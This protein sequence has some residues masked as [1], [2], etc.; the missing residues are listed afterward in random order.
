MSVSPY[1]AEELFGWI[2]ASKPDF[3]LL[4]V[5]TE[6]DYKRFKV[7][8]PKPFEM[9]NVPYIEFSD[10]EEEQSV[11][12]V[13]AGRPIRIVC[14]KEG[15]AKYVAEVLDG[16]GFKDVAYLTGGIKS[17]GNM[18]VPKPVHS[19]SG[20]T[21]F[22]FI[23]P[24]KASLSYGLICGKEMMLFDPGRNVE[25]YTEFAKE[26]GCRIVKTFE[27]HLQADYISGSPRIAKET[28][29]EILASEK[30]FSQAVFPYTP[31]RDGQEFFFSAGGPNVRVIHTPGHTPGSTCYLIDGHFLVSGDTVFIL[32]IGRPDLGGQAES[33]A[34]L[35]FD[36]LH[37]KIAPLP[38]EIQ[39]LPAHYMEWVETDAK[40]LFTDSLANIRKRNNE[41]YGIANEA[42]FIAF[43]KANMRPQP[44][45]YT[46][47]RKVNAGLLV[48]EPDEQEIMDLGKNE[49]AASQ[50][51]QGK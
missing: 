44:E 45:V 26:N 51:Q 47:I 30:D 43:I 34:K 28:G 14:A 11:A 7:E 35:E 15:S 36:T 37:H 22:Q 12:K 18:L 27:T 42:D 20:W 19:A 29:A 33:W 4:D 40:G 23:R 46:Q 31:L 21:L 17:W 41:I 9:M 3:V 13:P 49:C 8:G 25:F 38:G 1:K 2:E 16:H 48:V 32:S 5:R 39:V 24:G 10:E 50:K 6:S